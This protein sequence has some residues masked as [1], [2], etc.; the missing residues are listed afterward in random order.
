MNEYNLDARIEYAL[1]LMKKGDFE[2]AG[3]HIKALDGVA[4]KHC[5]D[6]KCV[7]LPDSKKRYMQISLAYRNAVDK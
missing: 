3:I 2:M 1:T 5:V 4:A 7:F 6:E